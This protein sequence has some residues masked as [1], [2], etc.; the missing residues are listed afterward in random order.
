MPPVSILI[1]PASSGCNIACKYCFYH[2]IADSRQVANYGIMSQEQLETLVKETIRYADGFACFAFQGGEPTLAG[3]DFF[4]K[5][6]ELQQKYNTRGLTIQN[7][8]QTNGTL[9]DEAWA[10]FL[11]ENKFLVGLSL[12]GPRGV[13][14]FCRVTRQGE[15]IFDQEQKTIELFEKYRVDFNVVSVVTSKTVKRTAGIYRFFREKGYFYQQYIPCLDERY[16]EHSEFSITPK[17]YGEF[18]CNLFDLWYEDFTR[19][20]KI[21]IRMFSNLAQMA[22]GYVPEECGMCGKCNTYFV[23]ESDGSVY[24]C[25]FYTQ[26]YWK[27]G[28]IEDGF[29][30]LYQNPK[31]RK[32]MEISH[33]TEPE[34]KEC[35]YFYLCRGGCRRWRDMK[36]DGELELNYLCEG[37]KLFFAHCESRIKLLGEYIRRRMNP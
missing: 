15:S 25:D 35:R 17:A 30:K 26:D 13:N 18:L 22:A 14:D 31:S 29:A 9:I 7:T 34:C 27:L 6:V 36:L 2:S 10:R 37:Y 4:R 11:G 16:G 21:D 19:G 28:T 23:V 5:A 12:D 8:I 33:K 20:L 24:P 32:F 3:L 1:K